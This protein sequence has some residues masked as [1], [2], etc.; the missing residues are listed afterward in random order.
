MASHVESPPLATAGSP[1]L[2]S[3]ASRSSP[4]TIALLSSDVQRLLPVGALV[5]LDRSI[6]RVSPCHDNTGRIILRDGAAVFVCAACGS[7]RGPVPRS[8]LNFITN[9]P[10]RHGVSDALAVLRDRHPA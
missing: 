2:R 9:I 3:A 8:V 6:D 7:D 1:G 10:R 5:R 4:S